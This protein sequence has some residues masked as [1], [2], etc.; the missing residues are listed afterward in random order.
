MDYL[1]IVFTY[2]ALTSVAAERFVDIVKRLGLEKVTTNGV[3]Y[4]VLSCIFG[5]VLAYF[6]PPPMNGINP[7]VLAVMT[8]LAV[9]G[10]SSVWN[11]ALST[12]SSYAK[13]VK[14]LKKP[15]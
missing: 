11:N 15:A 4:Q 1:T 10:G 14:E 12:L 5:G 7:W 8:G 9:S 13:S 6:N 2:F 3:V